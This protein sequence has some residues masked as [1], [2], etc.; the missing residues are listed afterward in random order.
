M[1]F[2][3]NHADSFMPLLDHLISACVSP[4]N[5]FF[6]T[7]VPFNGNNALLISV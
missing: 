7:K 2:L 6:N 4:N 3:K 5:L 1:P